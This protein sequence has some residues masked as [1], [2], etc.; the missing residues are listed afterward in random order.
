L[1]QWPPGSKYCCAVIAQVPSDTLGSTATEEKS[2]NLSNSVSGVVTEMP[3]LRVV[4]WPSRFGSV[5]R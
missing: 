1:T 2:P 3:V 5:G 4:S